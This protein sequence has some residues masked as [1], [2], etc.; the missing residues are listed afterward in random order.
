MNTK[1]SG[2]LTR[3]GKGDFPGLARMVSLR[4]RGGGLNALFGRRLPLWRNPAIL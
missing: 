3:P 2:N 4:S 1:R